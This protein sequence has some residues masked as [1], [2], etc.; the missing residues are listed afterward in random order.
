[1]EMGSILAEIINASPP[2]NILFITIDIGKYVV[3]NIGSQTPLF[4]F[5]GKV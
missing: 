5:T 3:D 4:Y 2:F 1:M